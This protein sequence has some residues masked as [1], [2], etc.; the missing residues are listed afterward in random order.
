M[1]AEPPVIRVEFA[2]Q[3]RR[4]WLL[5]VV[6]PLAL[7][8]L[9]GLIVTG[10]ALVFGVRSMRNSTAVYSD[11]VIHFERGSIGADQGS[12]IPYWIWQ[13]L[14]RLY[15]EAFGGRLD[16]RAFGFLYRS[17][18]KGHQ[19][20]L[21]IGISKRNVQ[22]VDL[23]WFNC[24]VCH[25]GTYRLSEGTERVVV[26]GMPANNLDLYAFIRFVLEAAADERLNAETLF[27]AMQQAGASFGFAERKLWEYLVIP[28][29]REGLIERRSR[30][31][32]FIA[33]AKPWGPGRVDTFNPYK[34]YQMKMTL[35]ALAP[36]ERHGAT[37]FPSIFN[38]K[39]R[40][41][42]KMELHWDGNNSSLAERNLS[43]AV[44]AGVTVESVDHKAI[45]RVADWLG[46]LR[47]PPSPHRPDPAAVA[48]G[49][50]IYAATCAACHGYQGESGY[51]FEGPRLGKVEPIATIGTDPGRLDAYTEAFRQR[52]LAELFA[53]TPY[54]FKFFV[55][56]NGYANV[57]LDGLW[58]RGPYLHNG[59]VPTLRDL[60]RRLDERPAAFVRGI[61]VVDGKNGGFQSP[62]CA[63]DD[64]PTQ[65]FC[66]DTSI[67]GNGNSGHAYGTNL[68][69]TE[70]DDVLAYLLTF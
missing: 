58:L 48:R 18:D 6:I 65:G 51:V 59:S 61:D 25:T 8:L 14:P 64:R 2:P 21:P 28:R 22:G 60:L 9:V 34:L 70:K 27:T 53:G 44:G 31:I 26:P 47:P 42:Q 12:G 56:T 11:N 13:A 49:R 40:G 62:R 5:P 37:D 55:K 38:Q 3:W 32:E 20:D 54:Q 33:G 16:Y 36:G 66:Y 30:L 57:P 68:T 39:P 29:T 10:F 63:P 24:A 17:D 23:V 67:P 19:E 15:P 35:G 7:L 69:A 52:Q 1:A 50:Q 43:A 46:T 45:E 4:I 41:D